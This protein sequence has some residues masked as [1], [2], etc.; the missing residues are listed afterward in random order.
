M[1]LYTCGTKSKKFGAPRHRCARAAMALDKAGYE[2]EFGVVPGYKR[3]P[4]TRRG[5]VRAE[6]EA[7]TGQSDVPVLV[8]DD[9][10]AING[11]GTIAR[12]A[13]EHPAA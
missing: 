8:L 2:H 12:W 4:W 9:G 11:S 1:K 13:K 6:I 3:L 7:L 10:E 5:D